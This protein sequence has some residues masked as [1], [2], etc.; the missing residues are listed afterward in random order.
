MH[1]CLEKMISRHLMLVQRTLQTLGTG[2]IPVLEAILDQVMFSMGTSHQ[3][4]R[5][6]ILPADRAIT[7]LPDKHWNLLK[8]DQKHDK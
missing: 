1:S 5:A 8:M 4:S 3:I 7:M 2:Y 6:G